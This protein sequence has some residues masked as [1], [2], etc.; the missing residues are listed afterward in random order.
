MLAKL[1]QPILTP[2][3]TTEAALEVIILTRSKDEAENKALF[4]QII[5]AIGSEVSPQN[6]NA[7]KQPVISGEL[8]LTRVPSGVL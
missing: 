7:L 2:P 5:E 6:T 4:D 1:L 3:S 8:E